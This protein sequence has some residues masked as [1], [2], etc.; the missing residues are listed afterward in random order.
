MQGSS[1]STVKQAAALFL[2]IS[3]LPVFAF[4]KKQEVIQ[5]A[6]LPAKILTAKTIYIDNESGYPTFSDVLYTKLKN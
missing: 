2:I 6:P 5:H 3:A 4:G 1:M